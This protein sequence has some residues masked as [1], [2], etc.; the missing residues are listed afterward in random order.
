MKRKVYR[1]TALLLC[2]GLALSLS[3]CTSKPKE[4]DTAEG[5]GI[6]EEAAGLIAGA[7]ES[8]SY[9]LTDPE[10]IEAAF[11]AFLKGETK[12]KTRVYTNGFSAGDEFTITELRNRFTEYGQLDFPSFE[13]KGAQSAYVD[14]G[15]DGAKELAVQF[16]YEVNGQEEAEELSHFFVF[17]AF[18]DGIELLDEDENFGSYY[19][20]LNQYGMI[21]T[22]YPSDTISFADSV[23]RITAGGSVEYIYTVNYVYDLVRAVIP[24]YYLPQDLTGDDYP[25]AETAANG[26]EVDAYSFVELKDDNYGEYIDSFS[27]VFMDSEGNDTSPDPEFAKF[28]EEAGVDI[29]TSAQ[30]KE[31]VMSLYRDA[32]LTEVELHSLGADWEPFDMPE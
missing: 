2:L 17:K 9:M 22:E 20:I 8:S 7:E 19:A 25:K 11:G 1:F 30:A 26:Y 24:S 13:F 23:R 28:Y 32:G 18:S 6:V 10:E 29:L 27:F 15:G 16:V 4:D 12:A 21:I 3:A 14:C 31:K 5:P